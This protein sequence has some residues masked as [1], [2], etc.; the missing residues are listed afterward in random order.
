MKIYYNI[1]SPTYWEVILE[2][3][4]HFYVKPLNR[5]TNNLETIDKNWYKTFF[6]TREEMLKWSKEYNGNKEVWHKKESQW[7]KDR[8]VFEEKLIN[9]IDENLDLN[10]WKYEHTKS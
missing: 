2:D 9:K 10:K 7:Y 6:K 4:L 3:E 5:R 8:I 1:D